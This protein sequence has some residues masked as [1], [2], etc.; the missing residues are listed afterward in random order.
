ME[1]FQIAIFACFLAVVSAVIVPATLTSTSDNIL[2]SP[3]NFAQIS[4]QSKTIQTPF[5]SS[6]KSDIRVTNPS[7]VAHTAP[8]YGAY[9]AAPLN[10]GYAAPVAHSAPLNYGYTIPAAHSD[11]LNYGYTA[12]VAH[13]APLNYGYTTPVAHATP[14]HAGLGVA[15]SVAPVVSHMSYSSPIGVYSY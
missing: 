10:Y 12:P 14:A 8:V 2:R 15:Y 5:S 13:A 1:F 11:P 4:T 3:G 6:S 7:V 9:S